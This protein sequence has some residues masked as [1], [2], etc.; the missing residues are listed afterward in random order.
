MIL[1][2]FRRRLNPPAV[3]AELEAL[4]ERVR[5]LEHTVGQLQGQVIALSDGQDYT[6]KLLKE[7]RR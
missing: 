7:P 6:L 1:L 3:P 4:R 5:Q 2:L